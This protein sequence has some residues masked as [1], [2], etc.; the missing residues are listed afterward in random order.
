MSALYSTW[1]TILD[2]IKI[3]NKRIWTYRK[4][5][6]FFYDISKRYLF[7]SIKTDNYNTTDLKKDYEID[8]RTI[9]KYV[10]EFIYKESWKNILILKKE[11]IILIDQSIWIYKDY[12]NLPY[13]RQ[14]MIKFLIY[15]L[16]H[17][18][19]TEWAK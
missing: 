17:K 3:K 10:W 4:I 14:K 11:D 7:W 2:Y 13:A 5:W 12:Q 1:L 18:T 8:P 16:L 6:W 9:K 19:K 15:F